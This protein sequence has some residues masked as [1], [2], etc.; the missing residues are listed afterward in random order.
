MVKQ[1]ATQLETQSAVQKV[2]KL[3]DLKVEW[4]DYLLAE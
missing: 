1:K 4:M 2:A 3:V